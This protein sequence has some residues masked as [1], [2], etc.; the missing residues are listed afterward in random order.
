MHSSKD[1]PIKTLGSILVAFSIF[2]ICFAVWDI[3][4]EHD[5][6]KLYRAT[7]TPR[8]ASSEGVLLPKMLPVSVIE[9]RV[10]EAHVVVKSGLSV[11]RS[12]ECAIF[13]KRNWACTYSD[14]SATFGFNGGE[15]FE[16]P[17]TDKLHHLRDTPLS[18]DIYLSRFAYMKLGCHW[19]W[20]DGNATQMIACL[21]RPFVD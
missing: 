3:F 5:V 8:P 2:W 16:V 1:G 20:V 6:V 19:D 7:P 10:S 14:R 4:G 9:I 13:D 15:Y 11:K 21:L 17:K 12:D 18:E